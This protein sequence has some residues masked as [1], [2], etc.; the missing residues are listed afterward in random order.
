[1]KNGITYV[2]KKEKLSDLINDLFSNID[3]KEITKKVE[4]GIMFNQLYFNDQKHIFKFEFQNL[5]DYRSFKTR[6]RDFIECNSDNYQLFEV[7]KESFSLY[8]LLVKDYTNTSKTVNDYIEKLKSIFGY[9]G[10]SFD[11]YFIYFGDLIK[12]ND[13]L[14]DINANQ[15]LLLQLM[16]WF[17]MIRHH[18]V[19]K[20][21]VFV[22]YTEFM[23]T[24]EITA[25]EKITKIML[26]N[27][28]FGEILILLL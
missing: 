4:F 10:K 6:L 16:N 19:S 27:K 21:A 22:F 23:N 15:A 26:T 13:M 20:M 12:R 2:N 18:Q 24:E 3:S 9:T 14:F 28:S 17:V 11:D 7:Y 1:M 8:K 25:V 5:T